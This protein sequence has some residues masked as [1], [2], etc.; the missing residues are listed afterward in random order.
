MFHV[1]LA[2]NIEMKNER[3][4]TGNYIFFFCDKGA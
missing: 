4:C 2:K 3:K 1:R